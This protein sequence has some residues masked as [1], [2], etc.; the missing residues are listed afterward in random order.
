MRTAI[1]LEMAVLLAALPAAAAVPVHMDRR[2]QLR[3]V[4]DHP[5][6]TQFGPIERVE[7][8]GPATWRVTS[9]RCHIDVQMV[10]VGR[11]TGLSPRHMEPRPRRPVC[12]PLPR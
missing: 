2:N 12:V 9:G 6:F 11:D 7:L 5:V 1:G 3:Q 10:P 8:V 4:I